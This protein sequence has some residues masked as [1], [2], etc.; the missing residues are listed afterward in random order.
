MAAVSISAISRA[1]NVVSVT[2]AS[3]HSLSVGQAH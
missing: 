1:S 3:A 2:A